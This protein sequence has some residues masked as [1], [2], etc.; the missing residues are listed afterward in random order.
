MTR[1][2]DL[3]HLVLTGRGGTA[4]TVQTLLARVL[5]SAVNM[6]T[7]VITA[8]SL[9]PAGR[10][11][12]AAMIL[13][14]QLL[15]YC[16]TLGLPSSLLYN[17]RRYPERRGQLL[18]AALVIA[19]VMGVVAIAVGVIGLPHWLAQYPRPVVEFA[20]VLM[21]ASPV[22]LLSATLNAALQADGDF[23][24]ANQT[25]YFPPLMTLVSLVTLRVGGVLTPYSAA[26]SYIAPG[27]LILAWQYY[28][29]RDVF[30]PRFR[31]IRQ[32]IGNLF[33]YGIR[34]YGVDVLGTL[35]YQI[36]QVL[37][38]RLLTPAGMGM[39]TVALGLSRLLGVFHTAVVTVVLP[40]AAARPVEEV[41]ALTGRAARVSTAITL[42]VGAIVAILGAVLLP[43]F[44]GHSFMPAVPVFRILILEAVLSGAT[45]ILAQ[46]FMAVN[47]PGIVTILQGT[48]LALTVPLM[49]VL[50][51]RYGLV[52][53]AVSLLISTSCRFIFIVLSYPLVL[54]VSW[55][56]LVVTRRDLVMLL[57]AL[58]LRGA[59]A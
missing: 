2:R 44:Y 29:R 1:A 52:G 5:I 55:P 50:V 8:R 49:L 14:P 56:D 43:L 33:H 17:L 46:A 9:G 19:P 45:W 27:S 12:Q 53:A 24:T 36:D 3:G 4:A 28:R 48:G 47:R 41:V 32:A 39:Y 57:H 21:I 6:A 23:T 31:E 10:G 7:G 58:R 37:V 30:H 25:L 26:L 13:W 38:V 11:E 42:T 20:Q 18:A 40:K 22:S 16:L 34:S 15:A 51:P 54:K 35:A 59:A